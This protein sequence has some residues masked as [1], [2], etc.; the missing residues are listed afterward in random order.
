MKII[1]TSLVALLASTQSFAEKG[2]SKYYIDCSKYKYGAAFKDGTRFI[3][4]G[5]K[6]TIP[7]LKVGKTTCL[8]LA[9]SSTHIAQVCRWANTFAI[10]LLKIKTQRIGVVRGYMSAKLV[11]GNRFS[12]DL[13]DG[14]ANITLN[15]CYIRE[16]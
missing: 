5:D 16:E 4:L 2:K 7:A 11:E 13:Q 1:L 3:D 6:L 8:E 12:A 10:D 9:R 14:D 15:D